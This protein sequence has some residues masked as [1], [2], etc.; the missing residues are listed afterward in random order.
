MAVY[1]ATVLTSHWYG[2]PVVSGTFQIRVWE[3]NKMVFGGHT[4]D[5]TIS[6]RAITA[7]SRDETILILRREHKWDY[8]GK[9]GQAAGTFR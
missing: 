9:V 6:D 5:V 4:F 1:T 8:T 2:A 3:D 7:A